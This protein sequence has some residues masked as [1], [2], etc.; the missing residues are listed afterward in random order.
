[1]KAAAGTQETQDSL[2]WSLVSVTFLC[3]VG[4]LNAAV[5]VVHAESSRGQDSPISLAEIGP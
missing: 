2:Y 4:P 5:T 1:M 3:H